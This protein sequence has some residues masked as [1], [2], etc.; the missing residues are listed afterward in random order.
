ML[1]RLPIRNPAIVN[2]PSHGIMFPFGMANGAV[3]IAELPARRSRSCAMTWPEST[4][5][6]R[7]SR[8][9]TIGGWSRLT[10]D[11]DRMTRPSRLPPGAQ[12]LK[13]RLGEHH[14][15]ILVPLA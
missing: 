12:K 6:A 10:P 5:A 2:C 13:Q 3:T 11:S 15:A 1:G 8:D 4:T 7:Q 14:V 9:V